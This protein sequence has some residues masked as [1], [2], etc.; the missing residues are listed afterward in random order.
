MNFYL[1]KVK[2]EYPRNHG[3]LEGGVVITFYSRKGTAKIED[4]GASRFK[5]TS[6]LELERAAKAV[7]PPEEF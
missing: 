1:T 4:R 3:D 6:I 5:P 7:R 2:D